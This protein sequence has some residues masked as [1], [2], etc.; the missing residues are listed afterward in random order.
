MSDAVVERRRNGQGLDPDY[1]WWP[2]NAKRQGVDIL[3]DPPRA[4]FD[5]LSR[6]DCA[7]ARFKSLC[8]L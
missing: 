3:V 2:Q 5:M 4:C 7:W 1:P 8:E 6:F